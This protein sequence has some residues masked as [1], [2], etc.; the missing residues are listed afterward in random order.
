M[1]KLALIIPGIQ[2]GVKGLSNYWFGAI[3]NSKD[4]IIP[5]YVPNLLNTQEK[6]LDIPKINEIINQ[7]LQNLV[8]SVK[9]IIIYYI[10]IEDQIELEKFIKNNN[11]TEI[12][13]ELRDLKNL[14]HD[15]VIEDVIEFKI[16][17]DENKFNTNV[18][19]FKSDRLI[20]KINEFNE[21]GNA[22][23]VRNGKK[24]IPIN[25]S[26]EGLEFIELIS[27]DTVNSEGK[28][29][30]SNEIKIDKLGYCIING[31]KT[32]ELW[33]GSIKSDKKPL[34]IKV[35]NICGDETIIKTL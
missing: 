30:S 7:E 14:L 11:A 4:G 29:Y 26:E 31:K 34:R 6:I 21:K 24:F 13:V 17:T 8:I 25:I 27:V 33:N 1:D 5:V 18:L 2:R 15:V 35:R 19:K 28:W 9:K 23:S 10:D 22:K 3:S 32:K 12:E 20:Q 16:D